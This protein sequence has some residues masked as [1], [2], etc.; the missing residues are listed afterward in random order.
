MRAEIKAAI[1]GA[2]ALIIAAFITGI[3]QLPSNDKSSDTI[4]SGYAQNSIIGGGS[5]NTYILN[6]AP[7]TATKEAVTVLEMKLNQTEENVTFTK[8]QVQLLTQALKDLDERTSALKKLPDGRTKFSNIIGGNPTI[9][10]DENNL[11]IELFNSGNYTGAFM[12]SQN[13]IRLYEDSKKEDA[14][15][16]YTMYFTGGEV[17]KLYNSGRL[18]SQKLGNHSLAYEYAKKADEADSSP[19]NKEQLAITLYNLGRFQEASE[20]IEK[21]LQAEPNNLEFMTLKETILKK[22]TEKK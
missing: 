14:S 10:A 13:A 20:F 2:I 4:N 15:A 12:H 19:S 1:I 3:F 9:V 8:E 22:L 11:A 16:F 6:N 17:S 21:A 18:I 5:G 7:D